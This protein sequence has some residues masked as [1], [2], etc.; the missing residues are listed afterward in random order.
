MPPYVVILNLFQNLC[1]HRELGDIDAAR[2][3]LCRESLTAVLPLWL[4]PQA[5]L[6]CSFGAEMI[7]CSAQDG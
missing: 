5:T 4:T 2:G 3:H 6:S 1:L 7:D